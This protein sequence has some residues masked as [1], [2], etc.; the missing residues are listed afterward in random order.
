MRRPHDDRPVRGVK[1]RRA[2]RWRTMVAFHKELRVSLTIADEVMF[3]NK[4]PTA[5]SPSASRLD[6]RSAFGVRGSGTGKGTGQLTGRKCESAEYRE[7]L[8]VTDFSSF[9]VAEG[10]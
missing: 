7:G 9:A 10:L 3:R 8:R 2:L 6:K 4:I 1:A 5:G